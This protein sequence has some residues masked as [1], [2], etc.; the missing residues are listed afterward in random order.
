M[1]CLK[2]L[3]LTFYQMRKMVMMKII[4]LNHFSCL[5]ARFVKEIG[6]DI[7]FANNWCAYE[8][9]LYDA[10][11]LLSQIDLVITNSVCFLQSMSCV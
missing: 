3:N 2:W 11:M 5:P 8:C 6:R 10:L 1:K 7:L 9:S 4:R